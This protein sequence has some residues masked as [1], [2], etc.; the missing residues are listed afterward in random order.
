M[1][2]NANCLG[3][4]INGKKGVDDA[5]ARWKN[6]LKP[7]FGSMRAVDVTSEQLASI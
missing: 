7:F 4:R 6:H 5:E 1:N 3:D 2:V